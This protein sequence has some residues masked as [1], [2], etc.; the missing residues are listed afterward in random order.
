[1]LTFKASAIVHQPMFTAMSRKLHAFTLVE[2]LV[3][4]AI[5]GMLIA[6][7]LPAV[8]AAREAARRMSC[9]NN[10]KQIGLSLH[11][12]HDTFNYFPPAMKA[13]N[14]PKVVCHGFGW[15]ALT[16]PFIEQSNLGAQLDFDGTIVEKVDANM[17]PVSGNALLAATLV[18]VFLCPSNLDRQLNEC[19]DYWTTGS[20]SLED[21]VSAYK[22]APSHYSGI[23]GEKISEEGKKNND[24][25]DHHLANGIFPMPKENFDGNWQRTKF[26]LPQSVDFGSIEGGTSNTIIVAEAASYELSNPKQ[27]ANGQWISGQNVFVKDKNPIN[28][29]PPCS[30]FNGK[31]GTLGPTYWE[32]TECAK[33]QHDFRSFHPSGA[34]ATY[35]DGSVSFL[36]ETMDIEVLSRHCNRKEGR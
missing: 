20:K 32:C 28:F 2:L 8:Q 12:Y 9:S 26:T 34:Y 17:N 22:R 23:S 3:V 16:L 36:S 1:M 19:G 5:I 33:Y 11:N 4:I 31:R 15:A 10:L 29:V 30:H 6:L 14:T 21:Y 25:S 7:L 35:A 18:P 24:N 27:C 13:T